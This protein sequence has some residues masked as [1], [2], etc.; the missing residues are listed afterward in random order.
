M[1]D[2][3]DLNTWW[4]T[5]MHGGDPNPY[6]V[7]S[8]HTWWPG[9]PAGQATM[10]GSPPCMG[11]VPHHAFGFP[12]MY[13]NQRYQV[14]SIIINQALRKEMKT[15]EQ[16]HA[17][18][19]RKVKIDR[20]SKC[21]RKR[22]MCKVLVSHRVSKGLRPAAAGPFLSICKCFSDCVMKYVSFLS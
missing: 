16:T 7:G 6:M 17:R 5:Q 13:L 4:G 10:V 18:A 20:E 1:S 12:T 8:P 3:F 15:S 21:P 19:L 11:S 9:Q 14:S 22:V 2:T